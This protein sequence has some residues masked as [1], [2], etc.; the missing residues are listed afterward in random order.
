MR[1]IPVGTPGYLQFQVTKYLKHMITNNKYT[2]EME[3]PK[4]YKAL[5]LLLVTLGV[6][7]F[8]VVKISYS[9]A[10]NSVVCRC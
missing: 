4:N 9:I 2:W 5:S 7:G 1:R 6:L 3:L 10:V 8:R